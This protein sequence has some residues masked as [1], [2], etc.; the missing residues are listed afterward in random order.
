[1]LFLPAFL[2]YLTTSF[3]YQLFA[4]SGT[5]RSLGTLWSPSDSAYFINT[6]GSLSLNYFNIFGVLSKSLITLIS[7]LLKISVMYTAALAGLNYSLVINLY[8]MSPFLTAIA[9]YKLFNETLN[10]VH[11]LGMSLLFICIVIIA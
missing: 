2:G 9:F 5:S 10:K 11:I 4:A 8:S 6:N 7:Q 1:M 3:S